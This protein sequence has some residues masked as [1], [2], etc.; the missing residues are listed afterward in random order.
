MIDFL[1]INLTIYIIKVIGRY[2]TMCVR[3]DTFIMKLSRYHGKLTRRHLFHL[4]E[5]KGT[6][7][8]SRFVYDLGSLVITQ[9][10]LPSELCNLLPGE[11]KLIQGYTK[12]S[13]PCSFP[14]DDFLHCPTN[15]NYTQGIYYLLS[16]EKSRS[17]CQESKPRHPV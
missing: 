6:T 8:R 2:Y 4:S 14:H 7:K 16:F 11:P 5:S 15:G 13:K 10:R 9:K 17:A 12:L 3:V 1:S